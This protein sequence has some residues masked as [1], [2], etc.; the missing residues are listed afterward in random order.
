MDIDLDVFD[1]LGKDSLIKH[2]SMV[3][4]SFILS[5]FREEFYY[6][7]LKQKGLKYIIADSDIIR[8]IDRVISFSEIKVKTKTFFSIQLIRNYL[9]KIEIWCR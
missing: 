4:V 6:S 5:F 9:I 1:K 7:K 8:I 2:L 3:D